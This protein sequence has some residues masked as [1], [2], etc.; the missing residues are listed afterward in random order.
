MSDLLDP[1]GCGGLDKSY[2]LETQ[3]I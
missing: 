1:A 2:I 3:L